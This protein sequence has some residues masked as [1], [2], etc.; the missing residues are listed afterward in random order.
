MRAVRCEMLVVREEMRA[1]GRLIVSPGDPVDFTI[2]DVPSLKKVIEG[3]QILRVVGAELRL[4]SD[5][6]AI[7]LS[8]VGAAV[9][10]VLDPIRLS[11][12][13]VSV[14]V[15]IGTVGDRESYRL[16]GSRRALEDNAALRRMF[17]LICN[18]L[19]IWPASLPADPEQPA[20]Q[21]IRW[22]EESDVFGFYVDFAPQAW[23]EYS[24]F[25][26]SV[27]EFTPLAVRLLEQRTRGNG[28]VLANR[29]MIDRRVDGLG[30]YFR[31]GYPFAAY[32]DQGML[33]RTFDGSTPRDTGFVGDMF[34]PGRIRIEVP[35]GVGRILLTI[36][37]TIEADMDQAAALACI[38][39]YRDV[40][41]RE[42]PRDWPFSQAFEKQAKADLGPLIGFLTLEAMAMMLEIWPNPGTRI[43]GRV[44][45]GLNKIG[46]GIRSLIKASGAVFLVVFAG[47]AVAALIEAANFLRMVKLEERQGQRVPVDK[48]DELYLSLAVSKFREVIVMLSVFGFIWGTMALT[49]KLYFLVCGTL[50]RMRFPVGPPAG[51][52]RSGCRPGRSSRC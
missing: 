34:G 30:I 51:S 20:A 18:R 40:L 26:A 28:N 43:A 32:T 36:T 17:V 37:S 46:A 12:G 50:P 6:Y 49:S 13:R 29:L 3:E 22:A 45:S 7:L 14:D 41:K 16:K 39:S 2:L 5:A 4:E 1:A 8:P 35:P 42:I 9:A 27:L 24:R 21:M 10:N 52:R 38:V 25:G 33:L 31:N 23:T 44:V 48:L 19:R 47:D 15:T 11:G